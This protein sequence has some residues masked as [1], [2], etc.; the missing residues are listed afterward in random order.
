[1]QNLTHARSVHRPAH[2]RLD[3]HNEKKAELC[4]S[5]AWCTSSVA[6]KKGGLPRQEEETTCVSTCYNTEASSVRCKSDTMLH[7]GSIA[8][9]QSSHALCLHTRTHK[10][11]ASS[12]NRRSRCSASK[13]KQS[14]RSRSHHKQRLWYNT[15]SSLSYDA[16]WTHAVNFFFLFFLRNKRIR[17]KEKK[18]KYT[19]LHGIEKQLPLFL[20]K[21]RRRWGFL[22]VCFLFFFWKTVYC[23][24]SWGVPRTPSVWSVSHIFVLVLIARN[25]WLKM[26][27]KRHKKKII[28]KTQDI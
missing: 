28:I 12:A 27:W 7:G 17:M 10:L 2:K 13:K 25:A 16:Y 18:N 14:A 19:N 15:S 9:K 26:R 24:L 23:C 6:K 21:K 22:F 3:K 1:M 20:Q 5:L 8:N 4:C 11:W